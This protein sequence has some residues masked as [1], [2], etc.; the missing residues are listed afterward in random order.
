M[1]DDQ[2]LSFDEPKSVCLSVPKFGGDSCGINITRN[3]NFVKRACSPH[4]SHVFLDWQPSESRYK[5]YHVF[6]IQDP[7]NNQYRF[8]DTD[9]NGYLKLSSISLPPTKVKSLSSTDSRLFLMEYIIQ[10]DIWSLRHV[11]SKKYISVDFNNN[12]IIVRNLKET[13]VEVN[14]GTCR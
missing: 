8:I 11:A 10:D 6:G 3:I 1:Q 12:R 2:F 4:T 5:S 14:I 7:S 9:E 13:A